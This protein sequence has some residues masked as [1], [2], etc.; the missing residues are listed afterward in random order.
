MKYLQKKYPKY[1]KTES[2]GSTCKGKDI[3]MIKMS[4][5][6]E[7]SVKQKGIVLVDACIHAREWITV[8]SALYII[9]HLL[10]CPKMLYLFDFYIIPCLNPDGYEFTHAKVSKHIICFGKIYIIS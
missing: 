6:T 2:I 10:T 3:Y 5:K 9:E 8:T 4:K 1:V 7:H